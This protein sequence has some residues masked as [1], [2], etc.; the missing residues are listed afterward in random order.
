ML[1]V[2]YQRLYEGFTTPG[3]ET[4]N[5]S[6]S[7]E[8]VNPLTSFYAASAEV[9]RRWCPRAATQAATPCRLIDFHA[10]NCET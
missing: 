6:Q 7:A 9:R 4:G 8:P 5:G 10:F 2:I 1:S 3:T